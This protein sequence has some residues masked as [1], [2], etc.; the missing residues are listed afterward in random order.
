MRLLFANEADIRRWKTMR[1]M[2]YIKRANFYGGKNFMGSSI[3]DDALIAVLKTVIINFI[4]TI[5]V[6]LT[7][8]TNGTLPS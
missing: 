8:T 5:L 4:Y 1:Q 2:N 6:P 3:E 7:K